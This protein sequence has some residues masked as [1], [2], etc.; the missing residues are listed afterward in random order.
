MADPF[1]LRV[2][3]ALTAQIKTITP[4]NDF[5]NDLSDFTDEAGRQ[6][7][8]VFRGRTEFGDNDP[9]P[10]VAILEDPAS[11]EANN[12]PINSGTGSN[13]FRVLIQG[14]VRDDKDHPLDPAYLLSAEVIRAISLSKTDRYNILGF[15]HRQPCVM[16]L[17]VGQPVHRPPDD[18]VSHV[19]YFL[20]PVVLT[21][22]EN[23]ETP[24]A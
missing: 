10:M 18:E 21:L 16:A 11:R 7:E 2:L 12:D 24:F 3:K 9:L 19:A 5:V 20:V 8:R 13:Q 1:R 17:S 4:D 22:A 6:Q 15:G 23:L 14:F